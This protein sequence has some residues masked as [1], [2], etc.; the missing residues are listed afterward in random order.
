MAARPTESCIA[1]ADNSSCLLHAFEKRDGLISDSDKKMP[2]ARCADFVYAWTRI[3][4]APEVRLQR[5]R[6]KKPGLDSNRRNLSDYDYDRAARAPFDR[7]GTAKHQF[8]LNDREDHEA[9]P[10]R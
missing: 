10:S 1:E 3:T 5:R 4:Q 7:A 2:L 9:S 6:R 8:V